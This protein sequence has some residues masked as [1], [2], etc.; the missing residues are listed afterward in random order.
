MANPIPRSPVSGPGVPSFGMGKSGSIRSG[1]LV[2]AMSSAGQVPV[3]GTATRLAG[4]A[5]P[6]ASQGP[7]SKRLAGGTQEDRT[8]WFASSIVFAAVFLQ[9][10][11]LPIGTGVDLV[12]PVGL[13]LIGLGFF[14]GVFAINRSRLLIFVVLTV[15][16]LLDVAAHVANISGGTQYFNNL[17]SLSLFLVLTSVAVVSFAEPV[18]ER[19]FWRAINLPM[20]IIAVAGILQFF[21]QFIGISIFSWKGLVPAS[22]LFESGYNLEIFIGVGSL[23]KS[24]GFFLLEPSVLA[25]MMAMALII[26][27]LVNRRPLPIALFV[28]G[29]LLSFSGTGWI[30]IAGFVLGAVVSLGWRGLVLALLLSGVVGAAGVASLFLAPDFA[31]ALLDRVGEFTQPST[32]GHLRFITPYW[33]A[34]DVL[35]NKPWVWWVGLGASISE[36][37]TMP[38]DYNV[39]TPVK[40]MLDFGLPALIL[41]L[42]LF[43]INRRTAAQR[44]LL[45]PSLVL[46]LFTGGY[47]DFPPILFIILLVN[48]VAWLRPAEQWDPRETG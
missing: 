45:A 6:G 14:R 12:G 2:P 10:L 4:A 22:F 30:V 35:A 46:F 38:Y 48:V 36:R 7:L 44:A 34:S 40:V 3:S 33:F 21:A 8:I 16:L 11:S 9:R 43:V 47:E 26:E 19:R 17:S 27:V 37:L 39:N 29:L 20:M 31:Y 41:Y 13:A 5:R 25:Q 23:L 32:S 28:T 18:D 42:A 15:L 1:A 24:N